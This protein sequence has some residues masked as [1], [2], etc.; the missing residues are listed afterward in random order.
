MSILYREQ[1]ELGVGAGLHATSYKFALK[2]ENGPVDDGASITAPLPA[3]S[4]LLNYNISPDYLGTVDNNV[5]GFT[6]YVAFYF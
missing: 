6:T 1:V 4:F 2:A 5:E 3:A